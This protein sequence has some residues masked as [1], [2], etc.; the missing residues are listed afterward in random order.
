MNP[1]EPLSAEAP[2]EAPPLIDLRRV[3]AAVLPTLL[4]G[5]DPRAPLVVCEAQGSLIPDHA[6]WVWPSPQADGTWGEV[7][8]DGCLQVLQHRLGA[9][10]W[11]VLGSAGELLRA[12]AA[13]PA[14]SER[15]PLAIVSPLPPERS[16]ISDYVAA[17]LPALSRHYSVV[18]I[19]PDPAGIAP[20]LDHLGEPL[21]LHPPGWLDRCSDPE[22]RILYHFGNSLFHEPMLALMR[23]HPGVVVLHDY[24]LSH[25]MDGWCRHADGA[26]SLAALLQHGHGYPAVQEYSRERPSGGH[27]HLWRY[28][29]NQPVLQAARGVLVHSPHSRSLAERDYNPQSLLN[30][31]QIPMLSRAPQPV[32]ADSLEAVRQRFGLK[33]DDQLICSFGYVGP[34][35]LSLELIEAFALSGL[36]RQGWMLILA[37]S[38][39][40][41]TAYRGMLEAAIASASLQGRVHVSGWIDAE[42]YA[43]LQQLS[44]INVQLRVQSRGETS[45]A[46]MDCLQSGT[47]LIVNRHGSL[48]DLPDPVCHKLP[49]RFGRDQ[50]AAALVALATDPE[51]RAVLGQQAR[52]LCQERHTPEVC[53]EAYRDAIETISRRRAHPLDVAAALGRCPDYRQLPR[54]TR[55]EMINGLAER[56]PAQPRPRRL[57]V[58]VS[59]IVQENLGTGIQRVTTNI[60]RELLRQLPPGWL[61]EPVQA[62]PHEPGYRTAPA[63]AA[64]LLD[65]PANLLNEPEP[66]LPGEGD[67]FLGLDLFHAVVEAQADWYARIKARGA[68]TWFVVYDLLPCQLPECF[69]PGTDA[70]HHRWLQTI[71]L[72]TGAVCISRT[73]AEELRE[74]I[75]A[76][77]PRD[78]AVRWFHQGADLPELRPGRPR[79]PAGRPPGNPRPNLDLL[80]VGTLEP[81]KGHQQ[82]LQA[83][84]RLWQQ[85]I[86]LNLT[87]IG[88]E[89]WRGLAKDQRRTLPDTIE[90][91]RDL[92]QRFPQRLR[93]IDNASDI[94]LLHHYQQADALLAASFGEGFGL[95]LMEARRNGLEVIARD[96]PVFREVLGDDG[97]F[98]MASDDEQLATWLAQ[99]HAKR[100]TL[101]RRDDWLNLSAAKPAATG[102]TWQ[103]SCSQLLRALAIDPPGDE[104]LPD[105]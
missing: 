13:E 35:K 51:A 10:G 17:L 91:L 48:D 50:L 61:V 89:G 44:S 9:P 57:F 83:M 78:C 32:T 100:Q 39:G 8:E 93:W 59:A 49:D 36:G 46:V 34:S 4:A 77:G 40:G 54:H 65:V 96:L 56:L 79:T 12:S 27:G 80:M 70:L 85:D 76:H 94:E 60:C 55:V 37:G 11:Q 72:S 45:A 105:C 18:L 62:T 81:R 99:W 43:C 101:E 73:V 3:E 15:P 21:P 86:Q 7:Y 87:I 38:E 90:L 66:V 28:S 31:H 6:L 69:P 30:W 5:L 20:Q 24:Y 92:C 68:Q 42:Q 23:R 103:E 82:V 97:L 102:I 41:N 88:R 53:A 74:W 67:L 84:E 63:Y 33:P 22:L 26:P 29:V 75:A 98:F 64:G 14:G 95:P 19:H 2:S 71:T 58:D 1:A 47:A 52:R 16:G 104:Q 25:L